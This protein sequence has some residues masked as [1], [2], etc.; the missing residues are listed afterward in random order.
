MAISSHPWGT[1]RPLFFSVMGVI[2]SGLLMESHVAAMSGQPAH[3]PNRGDRAVHTSRL[4][5]GLHDLTRAAT[6]FVRQIH[7]ASQER[8]LAFTDGFGGI[9]I[10]VINRCTTA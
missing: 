10:D 5:D 6:C 1:A 9:R 4:D 2:S 8:G 7:G 3:D